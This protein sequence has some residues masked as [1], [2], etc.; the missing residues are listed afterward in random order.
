MYDITKRNTFCSIKEWYNSIY[1]VTENINLILIGNKCDLEDKRE[2]SEEEGL[3]EAQIYKISYFEISAKDGINVEKSL[4][5][6]I[7][8]I[9]AKKEEKLKNKKEDKFLS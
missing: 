4:D 8:K 2:V 3:K 7:D 1:E 6:L 9:I 5:D